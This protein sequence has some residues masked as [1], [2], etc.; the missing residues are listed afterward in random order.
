MLTRMPPLK[1]R[2]IPDQAV[3]P[4][5]SQ[6]EARAEYSGSQWNDL[7]A[8]RHIDL[9]FPSLPS[10]SP[11]VFV[12]RTEYSGDRYTKTDSLGIIRTWLKWSWSKCIGG[13]Y[14]TAVVKDVPKTTI[15]SSGSSKFRESTHFLY[16]AN[17]PNVPWNH[18]ASTVSL[19]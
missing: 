19:Q 5:L 17:L 6:I 8:T 14:C 2:V 3:E 16:M 4:K 15:F 9:P 1:S 10:Y 7:L 18:L 12:R 11:F 13:E